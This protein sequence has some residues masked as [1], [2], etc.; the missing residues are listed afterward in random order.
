MDRPVK[1]LSG[2][3]KQKVSALIALT[4]EPSILILDEPTV[5]L[6][7]VASSKL[8]E[9]IV[10]QKEMG[11]AVLLTSHIM[12]EVEELSDR[13]VLLIEGHLKLESSVRELKKRTG[14]STLERAIAKLMEEGLD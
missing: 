11:K 2:G 1:L 4:Y 7:P 9:E 6:D 3:T 5:G 10:S 8:K 14:E 13:V 12:S